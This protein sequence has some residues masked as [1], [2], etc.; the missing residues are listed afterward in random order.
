MSWISINKKIK[1]CKRLPTTQ[2]RESCLRMLY[3]TTHDGIVAYALAEELEFQNKFEEALK[4]YEKEHVKEE[5]VVKTGL[6]IKLEEMHR[7]SMQNMDWER[8]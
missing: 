2:E 8:L 6:R 7:I 4:C 5:S 3:E 1:E